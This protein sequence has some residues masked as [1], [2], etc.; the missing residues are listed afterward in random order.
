MSNHTF[1]WWGWGRDIEHLQGEEEF[2]NFVMTRSKVS[3]DISA[4]L[5][6]SEYEQFHTCEMSVHSSNGTAKTLLA[7]Y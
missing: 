6:L 4:N 7:K 1:G 5:I 2:K 3:V